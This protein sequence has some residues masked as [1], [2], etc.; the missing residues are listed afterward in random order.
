MDPIT[1]AIVSA[2][3]NLGQQAVKD[4]Y[5]ALKV[6]IAQKFGVDSDLSKAVD[7]VE[8]KPDSDGRKGTLEEEILAAK[9]DKD[10][11]ILQ[12]AQALIEKIKE[13]PGGQTII[14]QTVTG[15][16]NAFSGSGNVTINNKK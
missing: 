10:A 5:E 6:L 13:Q 11:E 8:K 2:L 16:H 4:G 9:A 7:N 15:N 3:A 1:L 12:L 14:N